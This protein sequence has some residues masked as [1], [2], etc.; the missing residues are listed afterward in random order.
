MSKYSRHQDAAIALV[1]FLGSEK[2][3]KQRAVNQARLPTIPSLYD[4]P[5]IAKAQPIVASWGEVVENAVPRPSAPTQ[6]QYNEVSKEFWT[7]VN[8][9]L[10]GRGT[11][12]DNLD[13]LEKRL[14]R[15]KR[16]AWE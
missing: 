1:K 15:L 8:E 12:A 6:R 7:A 5:D 9:T 11:A 14:R 3:Q 13:K 16:S 10:S 2:A 4:D